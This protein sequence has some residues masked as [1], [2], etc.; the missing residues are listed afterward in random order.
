VP[1]LYHLLGPASARPRLFSVQAARHFDRVKVGQ[2][3]RDPPATALLEDEAELLR[4]QGDD[5]DW[6]NAGRTGCDNGGHDF[7]SRIKTEENRV[8]LIEYL[9]TL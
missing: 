7:W 9:K 8:D 5:R 4:L 3:L 1:T 2:A 6:F